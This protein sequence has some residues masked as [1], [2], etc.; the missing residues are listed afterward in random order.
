MRS[1]WD[2]TRHLTAR[3]DDS[4]AAPC[5]ASEENYVSIKS[6]LHLSPGKV[7]RVSSN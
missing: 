5:R 2:L 6:T 3:A 7:P 4:H 1:L